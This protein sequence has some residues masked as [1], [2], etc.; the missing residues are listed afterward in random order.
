MAFAE[1]TYPRTTEWSLD[2]YAQ[3]IEETLLRAGIESGWVLAESFGSQIAW[4]LCAPARRWTPHGLILAGGFGR[5]P[6]MPLARLGTRVAPGFAARWLRGALRGYATVARWRFRASPSVVADIHEFVDRRTDADLRA[7]LHRLRLIVG[8]HPE[9]LA[10]AVRGPVH[11]LTGFFDPVVPWTQVPRWL[12][13][14]CP[15]YRGRHRILSADHNVLGSAPGR[16][17]AVVRRWM[18]LGG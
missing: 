5:Y 9:D 6:L 3:A 14:H 13:T 11:Y 1:F 8:N 4:P 17:A 16:A 2:D 15:A 7:A 12:R 10:A 18:G